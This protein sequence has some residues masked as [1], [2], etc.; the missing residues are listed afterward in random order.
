MMLISRENTKA[1][2]ADGD[3]EMN[4][5]EKWLIFSDNSVHSID[6]TIESSTLDPVATYQEGLEGLEM[7]LQMFPDKS[8]D[9]NIEGG[10]TT[11]NIIN[12]SRRRNKKKWYIPYGEYY[13]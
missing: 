5:I 1:A 7:E 8:N 6:E 10:I 13:S 4:G 3:E 9:K 2:A 12:R 11:N